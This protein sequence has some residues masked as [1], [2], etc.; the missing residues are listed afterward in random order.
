MYN[1]VEIYFF[2][3]TC[4]VVFKWEATQ[5]NKYS[6]LKIKIKK[7]SILSKNTQTI[8]V[9]LEWILYIILKVYV[10]F[11]ANINLS[12][13][14][15]YERW[16]RIIEA[17]AAL[18]DQKYSKRRKKKQTQATQKAVICLIIIIR[19]AHLL[20]FCMY[21]YLQVRDTNENKK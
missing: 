8:R 5:T 17:E 14:I 12:I 6:D 15:N 9:C 16:I 13:I 2:I 18:I 3:K 20:S 19:R 10:I 4:V 21:I 7:K 1:L 11:V